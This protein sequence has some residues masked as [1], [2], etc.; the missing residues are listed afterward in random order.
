[1]PLLGELFQATT[2][3]AGFRWAVNRGEPRGLPR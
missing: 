3:R 1:M 2:T